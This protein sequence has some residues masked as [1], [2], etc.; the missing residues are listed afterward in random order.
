MEDKI[1][2]SI[3]PSR[4]LSS[5]VVP[6]FIRNYTIIIALNVY[7]E[8]VMFLSHATPWSQNRGKSKQWRESKQL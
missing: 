3:Y 4:F 8:S 5:D 2:F 6:W 1:S 7:Y